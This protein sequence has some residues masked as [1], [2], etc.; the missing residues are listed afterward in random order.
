MEAAEEEDGG[1]VQLLYDKVQELEGGGRTLSQLHR[2]PQDVRG[3]APHLNH[4]LLC[5]ILQQT[6]KRSGNRNCLLSA[7]VMSNK[8]LFFLL[9]GRRISGSA[10]KITVPNLGR[11]M[12]LEH[13]Y[14]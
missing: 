14:C 9:V 6:K 5:S 12:D 7:T 2:V 3:S 1:G 10:Q 11:L 13:W 4:V 8:F